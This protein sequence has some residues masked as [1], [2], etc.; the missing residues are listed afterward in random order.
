MRHDDA[1]SL[2]M[3]ALDGELHEA[4]RQALEEHLAGCQACAREWHGL[5]AIEALFRQAT[6]LSPA[7]GF[8][9]RTLAR[10]PASARRIWYISAIYSL[11]L[12][13]G[14]LPVAGL[15]WLGYLLAPALRQPALLR[16]LLQSLEQILPAVEAVLA[17][18]WRGLAS[19]GAIVGENPAIVGWLLVMAGVVWIWASVYDRLV[20]QPSR[21]RAT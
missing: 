20:F 3:E 19:T 2:M 10:L 17:G 7:A 16:T 15:I 18:L 9:N 4:G 13:S 6:A 8:T 21:S 14:L 5:L 1:Y 12:L 11:L